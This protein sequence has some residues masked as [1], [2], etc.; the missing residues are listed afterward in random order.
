MAG[1]KS[2][3]DLAYLENQLNLARSEINNLRQQLRVLNRIH[4]KE[5]DEI[6]KKM[7]K[8]RCS[9]C[10]DNTTANE[11]NKAS[12]LKRSS[13]LDA[14]S[15]NLKCIGLIHTQFPS[16]RG[17]PR[18]PTICSDAVGKLVLNNDVFTNPHHALQGLEQFS[19]MWI[20]F[21]F[22]QTES[23]HM[24]AKVSP[25][26]LDGLRMGVFG[27]RSPHRP[28]PLGLSL[29]RIN[30]ISE[31]VIYFSGVDMIDQTPVVDIKPYIPQYDSPIPM[32]SFHPEPALHEK[33][34]DEPIRPPSGD[35]EPTDDNYRSNEQSVID[36]N[37]I[38]TLVGEENERNNIVPGATDSE[39][40]RYMTYETIRSSSRMGER[41][42]PD[43]EE[44]GSDA[45]SRIPVNSNSSSLVQPVNVTEPFRLPVRIPGWVE[46]PIV[47]T[48]RVHFK[49]PAD[50]QLRQLGT[51]GDEKKKIITNVLSEDPRSVYLRER[52]RDCPYVFRIADLHVSCGFNDEEQTVFVF[53]VVKSDGGE[54][55]EETSSLS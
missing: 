3:C 49:M 47:P 5:C 20:I 48:L 19:H 9:N 18:Q 40:S 13:R 22:H 32:S 36:N 29:V 15:M 8:F 14:Y 52:Q 53:Q 33:P 23:T 34:D 27:T 28:S 25:P 44:E 45:I 11:I 7:N 1:S 30:Q 35:G 2:V 26:R 50:I 38:R 24:P 17:T 31:N 46:N 4:Q 21:H 39:T 42:A 51:E 37:E 16:K 54:H 6:I 55:N 10:V 12:S 41:E 43:G